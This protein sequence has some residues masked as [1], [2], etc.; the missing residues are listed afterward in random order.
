MKAL[1]VDA[2]PEG[3]WRLEIKLDGY[4]ALALINDGEV[5]LW[6]R[7]EK[8]L[9]ADYPEIV[10]ALG[11]IPC[12]N[13]AI[14]GEIVALD[15]E[16]RSRFQLLQGRA[17][18]GERP[19]IVYYAFDLLHH[20][21]RPLVGSAIEE[22]QMALQVLLGKKSGA[23]RFSPVFQ[24][25]PEKLLDEVRR[26]GLEGIIAKAA[27][28]RYEPGRRSGAWVKVKVHGEQE[29]VIGGFTAPRNSRTHF[30]AILVGYYE[31]KKLLYAGKVGTGFDRGLLASLHAE[32]MRRKTA[33]CPFANLPQPRK[34][35]FGLGM[36]ASAMR[37]VTWVKPALVAQVR[38]A[39]WTH[40]GLLRQPVFLGLRRD[41]PAR[42]VVREAA[43]VGEPAG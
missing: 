14:D 42:E 4:R 21:G 20:D 43:P 15:A 23:V 3:D 27:G 39:E 1:S 9:T 28:S 26:Q 40:D 37:D 38:F 34:P 16:G 36:T 8:E 10:A 24:M 5:R 35:R 31:G 22:R 19:P 11:K 18:N 6:S 41:K 2:L 29:F 7:N 17:M 32:F 25:Q 33:A 30:G 12:T 13:A